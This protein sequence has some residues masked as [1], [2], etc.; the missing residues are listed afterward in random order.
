MELT[1]RNLLKTSLFGASAITVGVYKPAFG[2]VA[3]CPTVCW[4][5][6]AGQ[7]I[8]AGTL[9]V[10]NDKDNLYLTYDLTNNLDT[11]SEIHVWIGSDLA[12]LPKTK[13]GIPIPGQFPF[14]R[15]F[16]PAV[17][18]YTLVVPFDDLMV[19]DGYENLCPAGKSL[20][21]V[22]HAATNVSGQAQTA[23]GGDQCYNTLLTE[24]GRWWCLGSYAVCCDPDNP[25]PPPVTRCDTAFAKGNDAIG[26]DYDHWVFTKDSKSNPE[27][28]P[29]LNLIR[30]R[31]GW[32]LNIKAVGTYEYD[33][34]AGA[35][36]NY[37]SKGYKAGKLVVDWDGSLLIITYN[38]ATGITMREVH[39]YASDFKPTVTAPGQYGY[40]EYFDPQASTHTAE[41]SVS[42]T[43]SDG[44]W[45]IA[46][47]VVCAPVT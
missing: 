2:Q 19:Q 35:G 9:C 15:S 43:N 25:P 39:I 7:T 41:F 1:R 13:K 21:I 42:D 17:N 22:A 14:I 30:N 23:F 11:I 6:I 46:H 18:S 44:I 12:N 10:T 4:P 3:V 31:W 34:Y 37:T 24:P 40:I 20:Y 29:S 26:P 45:I 38:L 47:A 16:N 8:N 32:A 36:L 28:L 33:I 27:S 5:L